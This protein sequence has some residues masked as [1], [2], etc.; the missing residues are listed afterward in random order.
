MSISFPSF[1]EERKKINP[2]SAVASCTVQVFRPILTEQSFS[3]LTMVRIPIA[4]RLGGHFHT[5]AGSLDTLT[6]RTGDV[7]IQELRL[8]AL[9]VETSSKQ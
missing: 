1:I 3:K 5:A 8:K 9:E 2:V 4:D 7:C 6:C